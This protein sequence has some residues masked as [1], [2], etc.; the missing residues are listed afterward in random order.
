MMLNNY[1]K[2]IQQYLLYGMLVVLFYFNFCT[3]L[4]GNILLGYGALVQSEYYFDFP[5]S[6]Y[7]ADY[8]RGLVYKFLLFA[9]MKVTAIFVDMKSYYAF[10]LVTKLIYYAL[11]FSFTYSALNIAFP[12][13]SIK[14]LFSIQALIWVVLLLSG[15]RQFME[16]EELA[17]V[18]TIGHFLFIYADDKKANYLSG[19]YPFLLFGCKAVTIAYSGF[20]LLYWLFYIND[21]E[22]SKRIILSHL[23]FFVLSVVAYASVFH[24]EIRNIL[25]AMAYQNSAKFDG[26]ST[27]IRFGTSMFRYLYYLPGLLIIPAG[28]LFALVFNRK[29]A[30]F[31]TLI[32]LLAALCVIVQ[33]RF[34]SPYHYLSFI[35]IILFIAFFS[36]DADK[37]IISLLLVPIFAVICMQNLKD[38]FS[39]PKASN[40][41]YTKYFHSQANGFSQINAY[42]NKQPDSSGRML[43]LTGD[44]PPY[45]ITIPSTNKMV[46]AILLNRGM[47]RENLHS[48]P[49]YIG[50]V[51]DIKN[52]NG[53]YILYDPDYLPL[54]NFPDISEKLNHSYHSVLTIANEVPELGEG[55]YHLYQ[56]N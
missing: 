24:V 44:C 12:Q 46:G 43:Y 20:A 11:C 33:N 23:G 2:P 31:I 8:I 51:Q 19:L 52:Y 21:K 38:T 47:I 28:I 5:S 48:I 27:L 9:I 50:L 1:I 37:K 26:I 45:F 49:A 4:W 41:L 53:K 22:K 6:I 17:V 32:F 29:Q 42:I 16:S 34:S 39:Y 56:R 54:A 25:T 55:T 40:K 14:Q 15:Y 3:P 36:F 7:E 30:L 13:K 10:Q 18:F 35:P